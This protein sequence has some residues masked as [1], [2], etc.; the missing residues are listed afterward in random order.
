V[1]ATATTTGSDLRFGKRQCRSD[2]NWRFYAI[3]LPVAKRRYHARP[4]ECSSWHLLCHCY[5]YTWLHCNH[6]RYSGTANG[7]NLTTT[8]T[9]VSCFG[10]N[11]GSINLTVAGGTTPYTYIVAKRRY[12]AGSE[13]PRG[14][15]VLCYGNGC[16]AAQQQLVQPSHNQ[17]A[18]VTVSWCDH[19]CYLQP[20]NWRID[21][22]ANGWHTS[23]H[24]LVEQRRYNAGSEQPER[25]QLLCNGDGCKGCTAT[26]CFT[27]ASRQLLRGYGYRQ[28]N[29]SCGAANGSMTS[30]LRQRYT[31]TAGC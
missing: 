12:H 14:R 9:N 21:I 18:A 20:G 13:Q 5:R 19:Q 17:S 8:T 27:V 16:P 31:L 3:H 23:L 10:G 15:H 11:N 26:S 4:G 28:P 2:S 29:H 25:W 7:P 22:T 6:L 24:I 1:V 30:V